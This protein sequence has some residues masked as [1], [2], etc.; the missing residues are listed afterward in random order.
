M[1]GYRRLVPCRVS[2]L[3]PC[4]TV[5]RVVG[6]Q[7]LEYLRSLR[8]DSAALHTL[9]H[10]AGQRLTTRVV[11]GALH[12]GPSASASTVDDTDGGGVPGGDAPAAAAAAPAATEAPAPASQTRQDKRVD[13]DAAERGDV[14][15]TSIAVPPPYPRR[16]QHATTPLLSFSGVLLLLGRVSF[17]GAAVVATSVAVHVARGSPTPITRWL[18]V[19]WAQ[20]QARRAQS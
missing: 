16:P 5:V 7:A 13:T 10:A 19:R 20:L 8:K 12:T 14:V 9:V 1:C 17:V 2:M 4:F 11:C 6:Q 15:Q 3:L 18:S